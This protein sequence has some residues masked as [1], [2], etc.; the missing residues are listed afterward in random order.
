MAAGRQK[1]VTKSPF[2]DKGPLK[3]RIFCLKSVNA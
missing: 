1:P 2:Y 3:I